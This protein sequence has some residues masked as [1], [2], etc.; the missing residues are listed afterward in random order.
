MSEFSAVELQRVIGSG[1][2]VFPVTHATT[3]LEFDEAA[4]REH[5]AHLSS[6]AP[7]GI[8]AAGGMGEFFSIT[9]GEVSAATQ[10]ARAEASLGIPVLGA[11]GYGTA[12]AVQMAQRAE[13]DGADGILLFPPYLTEVSQRGLYEHVARV[14]ASTSIGVIVYHRANAR[15]SLGT[16]SRLAANYDNFIGF[17][18]GIGEFELITALRAEIGDRLLYTGGLPTAEMHARAFAEIGMQTYSSAIFNF[19]PHWALDFYKAVKNHDSA[20]LDAMTKSFLLP[21]VEIRD[22]EQGYAVAI[23]KAGLTIVGHPAGPVRPPL[24]DLTPNDFQD[25][26]TLIEVEE[27]S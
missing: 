20:V 4:Y 11:A 9:P 26:T 21:Y 19:A 3:E 7:A 22:R 13:S 10:A 16:L 15:Y 25:L 27:I 5:V 12:M 1:L 23:V 2:L 6:F 24:A 8:F 17:K 14:C 18:D